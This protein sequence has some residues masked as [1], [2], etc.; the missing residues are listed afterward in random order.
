MHIYTSIVLLADEDISLDHLITTFKIKFRLLMKWIDH[1]KLFINW[2]KTK[3]FI[4]SKSLSQPNY[5]LINDDGIIKDC[6]TISLIGV[7]LLQ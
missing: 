3:F 6:S 4:I 7:E 1:N 2:S 5:I